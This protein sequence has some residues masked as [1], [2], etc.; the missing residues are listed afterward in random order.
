MKYIKHLSL[1]FLLLFQFSCNKDEE[2]KDPVN[3]D[4]DLTLAYEEDFTSGIHQ[5]HDQNNWAATSAI[6]TD[7]GATYYLSGNTWR[8]VAG[9]RSMTDL[10]T[11]D[12]VSYGASI[13]FRFHNTSPS[14]SFGFIFT[15]NNNQGGTE[16]VRITRNTM[17]GTIFMVNRAGY[18]TLYDSRGGTSN[19]LLRLGSGGF[20]YV[21]HLMDADDDIT[22]SVA[23]NDNYIA[24]YVNGHKVYEQGS[25]VAAGR[26]CGIFFYPPASV[27]V[28]NFRTYD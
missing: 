11:P 9:Y 3:Q 1:L 19:R 15:A 8:T 28:K 4:I 21:G 12:D 26:Y 14:G 25:F 17:G 20:F 22:L 13:T 23:V 16:L 7:T 27:T 10:Q 2:D 6:F 18:A 24:Y 5:V